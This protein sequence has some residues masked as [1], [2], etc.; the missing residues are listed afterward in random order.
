MN[1]MH[2]FLL[3]VVFLLIPLSAP[4]FS[5]TMSAGQPAC[6]G[7]AGQATSS[8]HGCAPSDLLAADHAPVVSVVVS[9]DDSAG[10]ATNRPVAPL[11]LQEVMQHEQAESREQWFLLVIIAVVV[12]VAVR[13]AP[14]MK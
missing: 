7:V 4:A 10:K 13:S 12:L 8:A 2:L 9:P 5:A 1:R 14:S 6:N 11:G 3:F